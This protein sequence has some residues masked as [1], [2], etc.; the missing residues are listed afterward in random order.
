MQCTQSSTKNAKNDL[1]PTN[2]LKR[3]F[4]FDTKGILRKAKIKS[5]KDEALDRRNYTQEHTI[6][7]STF[8][9]FAR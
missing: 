8:A 4:N 3:N 1:K 7:P 5:R 6:Q 9:K 2:F